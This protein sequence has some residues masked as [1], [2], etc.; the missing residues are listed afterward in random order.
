MSA[1]ETKD[2][3]DVVILPPLLFVILIG[4]GE[5]LHAMAPLAF[6]SRF[7]PRVAIGAVVM[8]AG[9]PLM[10]GAFSLFKRTGQDANPRTATPSITRDGPY[11]FTRNPMYIAGGLLQLGLGIVRGNGWIVLLLIP[12]FLVMSYGVILREEAYLERKFGED[13]L[14]YKRSV[15]RWL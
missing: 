9:V 13:Y 11:R 1:N 14:A 12:G 10:L 6:A 5:F 4:L 2:G 8:A 3:A 7:G 15:R